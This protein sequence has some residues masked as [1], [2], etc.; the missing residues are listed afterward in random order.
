MT[1]QDFIDLVKDAFYDDA[2]YLRDLGFTQ[3]ECGPIKLS[4]YVKSDDPYITISLRD[5]SVY[6][7]ITVKDDPIWARDVHSR[8]QQLLEQGIQ[9]FLSDKEPEDFFD[10]EEVDEDES[11][12]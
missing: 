6:F 4:A 7:S 2:F 10:F 5:G 3:I 8:C 12:R 9:N 1:K 11:K